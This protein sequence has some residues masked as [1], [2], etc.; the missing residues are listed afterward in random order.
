MRIDVQNIPA[1]GQSVRL[2]GAVG[3]AADAARR[4]LEA[5]ASELSGELLFVRAGDGVR[6]TGQVRTGAVRVCERCAEE[7]ALTFDLPV[8]LTYVAR[9]VLAAADADEETEV[10]LES[11]ELDVSFY[12]DGQIDVADVICEAIALA[13]PPRVA[14]ADV[15]A[16]DTRTNALLAERGKAG[17]AGHPAFR[18]LKGLRDLQ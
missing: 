2:D 18:V 7:V 8:D 10:E 1:D 5:D 17:E 12:D 11:A 3:W 13:M 14:C 16:C 9:D 15:P 4:A 6:V